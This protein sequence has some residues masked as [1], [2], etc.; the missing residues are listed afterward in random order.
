MHMDPNSLRYIL[1]LKLRKFRQKKGLGL[2][3]MAARTSLSISY[4][5]EI[6]KGRKYPKPEK[7]LALAQA[8]GV[9]FDE[10][11]SLK[12]D[13]ELGPV[14]DI[15]GSPFIREF[16]F[17]LYGIEME[18]LLN[19]VT[20]AP[21]K[22]AALIRTALEIGQTYDIQVEHFLFAALRSYQHMHSNYFE[23]IE[24]AAADFLA[25]QH[26]HDEVSASTLKTRLAD[27]Y[28]TSVIHQ[29]FAQFPALRS[30]RSI[31]I[32]GPK[33]LVNDRLLESQKTFSL[34]R[35]LGY[36]NLGLKDRSTTSPPLRIHSFDQVINDFTAAYFAGAV[37][38]PRDSLVARLESFFKTPQW[39]A[40]DLL[41]IL[42]EYRSTPE[43][44]FYRLSQ[45]L[46]KFFGLKELFFLR[47]SHEPASPL[48]KLGKILNMSQLPIF[49]GLEPDEHY[50]RRWTGIRLLE[51]FAA[52]QAGT[53]HSLQAEEGLAGD[54]MA[55]A[56][57]A[58][59]QAADMDFFVITL[60]RPLALA[61]GTHS[62]VSLGVLIDRTFKR[63][64]RFWNDPA[65]GQV[66]VNMTCERC[67]LADDE[68]D[69]RAAPP[70]LFQ[71][72][73]TRRQQEDQ[74]AQLIAAE[75][76]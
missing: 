5:S 29:D 38:I 23:D 60:T 28:G 17:H 54:I 26:A 69:A 76:P 2:K 67:G 42:S 34:A 14:T 11:V 49:H 33:L 41:A 70:T 71:A 43:T 57:R 44:L 7:L 48:F 56:Q 39:S 19:L 75:E 61:E 4:L 64:V 31:H 18:R 50:C 1:G 36:L 9:P 37:I 53:T 13:D 65:I 20:E 74:L 16:P 46:P 55:T 22:A 59:F 51:A 72:A 45:L 15:F 21:S 63:R 10:L 8:L 66:E 30:L 40:N 73:E 35:E 3:D 6:E 27:D 52:H 12:V 47:F 62:S 58:T 68:C 24:Q 25:M 32:T